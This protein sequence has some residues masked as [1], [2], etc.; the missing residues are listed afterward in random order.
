MSSYSTQ[1]IINDPNRVVED[2]LQGFFK[3]HRGL[4]APIS[5]NP[6]VVRYARAPIQGKVGVVTGGGSG[7]KPAFTGLY[8]RR[9]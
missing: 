7:H 8:R 3:A 9:G 1:R 5:E 4:V 6:R 2:M